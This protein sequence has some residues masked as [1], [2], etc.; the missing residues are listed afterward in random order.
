MAYK[1]PNDQQAQLIRDVGM[2]PEGLGV[3]YESEE[4][5]RLFHYK[6]GNDVVIWKGLG[7]KRR[8]QASRK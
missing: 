8:E 6:S 5:L 3:S 7:Q 1:A 4:C 2:D